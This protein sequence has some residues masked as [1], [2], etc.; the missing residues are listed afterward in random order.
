[1]SKCTSNLVSIETPNK[2][3]ERKRERMKER[4]KERERER[5]GERKNERWRKK[6]GEREE[7]RTK[8]GERKE[9]RERERE[10]ERKK[11]RCEKFDPTNDLEKY[12][13]LRFDL[14]AQNDDN[15]NGLNFVKGWVPYQL[16]SKSIG[17]LGHFLSISVCSIPFSFVI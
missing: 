4:E 5:K 17:T 8:D 14:I 1:M 13:E 11:D 16:C 7:E 12:F 2:E 6:G 10:K 3:K 9:E 15:I